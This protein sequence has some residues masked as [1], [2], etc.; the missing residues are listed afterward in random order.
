VIIHAHG[1]GFIA[2]SSSTMQNQTRI[3]SKELDVVVLSIDYKKPP[4][5]RFPA[6]VYDFYNVYSFVC[7]HI[8]NFCNISPKK[9]ILAGDSAGGNLVLSA[10][11]L[12]MKANLP[13]P[14]GIF[15]AYPASDLRSCYTP[16]RIHA[17]EDAILHPSL[18]LL[19]M[20]EYLG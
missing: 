9:I 3:W 7:K 11:A 2:L 5:Y 6:P 15:L 19:C 12:A 16:S 1:G 14:H 10:T 4:K 18:L 8:Q 17:F 20:R 13:Q